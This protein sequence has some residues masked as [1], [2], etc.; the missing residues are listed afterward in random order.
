MQGN[1]MK[2]NQ[3]LLIILFGTIISCSSNSINQVTTGEFYIHAKGDEMLPFKR[4]SWFQEI[5]MVYD[6]MAHKIDKNSSLYL[7]MDESEKKEILQCSE[8][9]LVLLYAPIGGRLKT[10]ELWSNFTNKNLKRVSLASLKKHITMAPQYIQQGLI[11]YE[12]QG[13]CKITSS[14]ISLQVP[15]FQALPDFF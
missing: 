4:A 7:L 5:T 8:F 11:Q 13:G 12:I 2:I 15:G 9:Y 3:Y 14:L 6:I 1:Y 10:S